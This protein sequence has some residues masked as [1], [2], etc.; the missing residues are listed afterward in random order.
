MQ[1]VLLNLNGTDGTLTGIDICLVV[2]HRTVL[3]L[4]LSK[5]LREFVECLSLQAL[6]QFRVLR[7]RRQLVTL[8]HGLDIQSRASTEDG[9]LASTYYIIISIEEVLLI[10]EEVVLRA[11]L[12]N[13]DKMI[14]D[15]YR[16]ER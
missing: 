4:Q 15:L 7:H 14:G 9:C 2:H 12:G 16:G 1:V 8:Q 3:C 5:H 13:V 10:L 11:W 6:T